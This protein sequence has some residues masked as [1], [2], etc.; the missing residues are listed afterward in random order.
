MNAPDMQLYSVSLSG[1]SVTRK[2]FSPEPLFN[3]YTVVMKGNQQ[4]E[5]IV[6]VYGT[7]TGFA[8]R[9]LPGLKTFVAQKYTMFFDLAREADGSTLKGSFLSLGHCPDESSKASKLPENTLEALHVF[10]VY[11]ELKDNTKRYHPYDVTDKVHNAA[12]PHNVVI[13][14]TGVKWELGGAEEG[15]RA[16]VNGWG[17]IVSIELNI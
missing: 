15:L 16:D 3:R 8:G 9:W 13:E 6:S 11:G 5:N 12:D 1:L 10:T 14:C 4:S 2:T 17:E 7:L